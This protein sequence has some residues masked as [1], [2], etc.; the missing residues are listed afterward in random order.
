MSKP[1]L[2]TAVFSKRTPAGY[3]HVDG[4]LF[5]HSE[6]YQDLGVCVEANFHPSCNFVT[7]YEHPCPAN[8]RPKLIKGLPLGV[9]DEFP[10]NMK[11]EERLNERNQAAERN[12]PR[13]SY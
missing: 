1:A 2:P 5:L 10:G 13:D 3:V 11:K 7:L 12:I 8:E 9:Y 4:K 6:I